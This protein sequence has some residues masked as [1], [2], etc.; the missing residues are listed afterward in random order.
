MM[1]G[2]SPSSSFRLRMGLLNW[3]GGRRFGVEDD[4][5][6]GEFLAG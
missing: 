3:R 4:V 6:R 5:E 1:S 2:V